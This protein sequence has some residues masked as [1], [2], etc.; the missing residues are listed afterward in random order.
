MDTRSGL[1]GSTRL[2]SGQTVALQVG[3]S[4]GIP[5]T[6]KAVS[7]NVASVDPIEAGYVTV[8][9]CDQQRPL[10]A[11]LN[12]QPGKVRPNLVVAP[13]ADDGTVCFYT[14]RDVDLVV[15]AAGYLSTSATTGFTATVPFRFTDTRDANR[16]EVNAG[17]NG[18]PLGG[19]QI[20]QIQ[21]AGKRGVPAGT[22]AISINIAVTSA[23]SGG[24]ITA[25]P[26]G[27]RPNTASVNYEA[28]TAISNGAT[29][30]LSG[31]GELCLYTYSTAH[32][33]VDVN[34]WWG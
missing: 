5:M 12:P 13:L 33:I 20:L 22:K 34:G 29:V 28:G 7:L 16:P 3:G 23:E 30:P 8:Y 17:T 11:S 19:G 21:V 15:D 25:W 27:P 6:A 2:T 32:V 9:P 18:N 1:G 4:A 26:C 31:A 14:L 10:A 24:F